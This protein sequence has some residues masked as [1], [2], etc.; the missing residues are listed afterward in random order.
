MITF[1]VSCIVTVCT[2]VKSIYYKQKHP[3][4]TPEEIVQDLFDNSKEMETTKT[5]TKSQVIES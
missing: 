3:I 2:V 4:K 5:T 1:V